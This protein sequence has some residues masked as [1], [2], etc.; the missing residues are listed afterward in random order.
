LA[1]FEEAELLPSLYT[2]KYLAFLASDAFSSNATFV[3]G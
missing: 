3:I 1:A 2:E